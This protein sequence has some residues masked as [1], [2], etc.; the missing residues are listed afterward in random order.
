MLLK[1]TENTLLSINTKIELKVVSSRKIDAFNNLA[2]ALH[3]FIEITTTVI[4]VDWDVRISNQTNNGYCFQ[5][6]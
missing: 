3:Y 1:S 6:C 4:A 5:S 2:T